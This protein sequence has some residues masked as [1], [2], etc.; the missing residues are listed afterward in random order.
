[1]LGFGQMPELRDTPTPSDAVGDSRVRNASN[2]ISK[3]GGKK[4]EN[5]L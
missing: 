1:M 2:Q 4:I 5:K 3:T